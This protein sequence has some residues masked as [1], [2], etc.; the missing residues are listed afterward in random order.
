[1]KLL[2]IMLLIPLMP[3]LAR[4]DEAP[5]PHALVVHV[6]PATSPIGEPI[7]LEAMRRTPR[8]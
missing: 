4:A 5:A 7:T 2:A 6:P 8:R 3:A 1:M